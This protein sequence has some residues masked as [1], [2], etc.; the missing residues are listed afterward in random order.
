M[1]KIALITIV[2]ILELLVPMHRF[3]RWIRK[4]LGWIA[5]LAPMVWNVDLRKWKV[6]KM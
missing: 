4:F 6:L 2:A 3:K 1:K 5:P